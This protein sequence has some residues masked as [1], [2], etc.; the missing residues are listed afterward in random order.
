MQ[1]IYTL[2]ILT[3]SLLFIKNT[4]AVTVTDTAIATNVNVCLQKELV[5]LA[6]SVGGTG[7]T[8]SYLE[9]QLPTGFNWAGLL[10]VL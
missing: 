7:T 10:M 5:R 8:G 9:I 2:Y 4:H 1:K 6:F 3:L